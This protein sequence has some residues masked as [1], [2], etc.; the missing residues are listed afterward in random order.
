MKYLIS[1]SEYNLDN[2]R[3]DGFRKLKDVNARTVDLFVF[4][5]DAFTY[6]LENKELPTEFIEQLREKSKEIIATSLT[7]AVVVRRAFVVPGLDNPPGPYYLG[8][9][10]S[11]EVIK[12]VKNLFEFAISQ[13]YH[14]K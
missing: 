11:D 3:I 4:S 2:P 7:H 8:L 14:L 5:L 1:P 6:F 12:A 10:T 9:S 13:D